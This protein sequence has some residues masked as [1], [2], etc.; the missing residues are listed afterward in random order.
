MKKLFLLILLCTSTLVQSQVIKEAPNVFKSEN[1]MTSGE[2]FLKSNN[3]QLYAFGG[4]ALTAF[5]SVL[6]SIVNFDDLHNKTICYTI[7]AVAGVLT[8]FFETKSI[9]LYRKGARKLH[10]EQINRK[11]VTL[12]PSSEGLGAKITF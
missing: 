12:V 10:N 8:I 11:Y 7:S 6:P 2:L 1:E 4:V 3:Y 5:T 9:I